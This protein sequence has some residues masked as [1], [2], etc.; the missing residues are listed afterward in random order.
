MFIQDIVSSAWSVFQLIELFT[1]IMCINRAREMMY[2]TNPLPDWAPYPDPT[3]N[4]AMQFKTLTSWRRRLFQKR[5]PVRR[6]ADLLTKRGWAVTKHNL[7]LALPVEII[8][9]IFPFV[10]PLLVS[11][12]PVPSL[13]REDRA[14]V[15]FLE[16]ERKET[17]QSQ[18]FLLS[19]LMRVLF[20][21]SFDIEVH[22]DT[23]NLLSF[24]DLYGDT[25]DDLDAMPLLIRLSN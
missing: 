11:I 1:T 12:P 22:S 17:L 5:K 9:Y 6:P 2:V 21:P 19:H 10:A 20:P 13:T 7:L 4:M 14:L 18:A 3:M 8:D 23:V 24:A 16:H 25:D 15:V